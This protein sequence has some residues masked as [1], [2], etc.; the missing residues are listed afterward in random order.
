[1]T[2]PGQMFET[3][4]ASQYTVIEMTVWKNAPATLRQMLDL[5]LFHAIARLPRLRRS[6][7]H[8]RRALPLGRHVGPTTHR[9]WRDEGRPRGHRRAQP[10]PSGSSPFGERSSR[11]PSSCRSTRWWTT[12]ELIYGLNDSGTSVL[13]VDEERLDRIRPRSTNSRT[14]H[15]SWSSAK[16]PTRCATGRTG[17]RRR[18]VDFKEFVGDIDGRRHAPRRRPRRPTTT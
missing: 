13:F 3:E 11:A 16:S 4:R 7:L 12:D 9:R 8:L 15:R 10:S 1:M 2:A 18:T 6:A 17:T 14:T 5:S